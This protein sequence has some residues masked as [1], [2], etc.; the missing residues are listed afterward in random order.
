MTT[1]EEKFLE[2]LNQPEIASETTD[3]KDADSDSKLSAEKL[4]ALSQILDSEMPPPDAIIRESKV[5]EHNAEVE[6]KRRE[7]LARRKARQ[8]AIGKKRKKR[9]RG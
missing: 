5:A 8:Q 7:K 9:K 3:S 6:R 4:E 2:I 1:R